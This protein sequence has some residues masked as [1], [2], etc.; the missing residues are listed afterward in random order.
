MKKIL[1]TSCAVLVMLGWIAEATQAQMINYNRRKRY[2]QP[3]A[4]AQQPVAPAAQTTITQPQAAVEEAMPESSDLAGEPAVTA[5]WQRNTPKVT[6]KIEK[7][8]DENNN[9]MLE[10]AEVQEFLRDV[11]R[12]VQQS[13][14]L[15]VNSP[16][17]K[18]YDQDKDGVI[19]RFEL[20]DIIKEAGF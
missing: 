6:N 17:L 5:L 3:A 7:Q 20:G 9:K 2:Q 1:W 19:S 8:Y 13:G 4:Q 15:K 10:T 12:Q 18:E 16:I 11:I 14:R